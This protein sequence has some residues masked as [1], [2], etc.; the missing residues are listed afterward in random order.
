MRGFGRTGTNERGRSLCLSPSVQLFL[1]L[2]RGDTLLD[3]LSFGLQVFEI[4]LEPGCFFLLGPETPSKARVLAAAATAI[5]VP[6]SMMPA[7]MMT[8]SFATHAI[9]FFPLY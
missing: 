1:I 3:G 8:S 2:E 9:T 4:P 5:A 6:A 7:T